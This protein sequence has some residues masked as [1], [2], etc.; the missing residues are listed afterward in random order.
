MALISNARA[1]TDTR[2]RIA[3]ANSR[4]RRIKLVGLGHGGAAVVNG[5]DTT[6]LRN[7]DIVIPD[8]GAAVLAAGS[9]PALAN[10]EMIFLVACSG[11]TLAWAPLIKQIARA[12]NVMVTGI[13]LQSG[14]SG[15]AQDELMT[16][17][18]ASDMLIVTTDT[19]YVADMLTQLGA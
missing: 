6:R 4:P 11:D 2:H 9:L 15:M 18:A 14:M 5:I 17:R 19:S 10:A 16:L 12:A 3:T 7:V 13:L 1:A 8:G